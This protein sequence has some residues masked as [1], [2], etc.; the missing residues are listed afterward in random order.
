MNHGSVLTLDA[1]DKLERLRTGEFIFPRDL[2]VS[3]KSR[4]GDD[5]W[6][7]VD[8]AKPRL[9]SISDA[10][11]RIDW[12]EYAQ[13]LS[14]TYEIIEDV[15]RMSLIYT[16]YP[17]LLGNGSAS[18]HPKT[19]VDRTKGV[20]R[21]V[22]FVRD[23]RQARMRIQT[24]A[25]LS[26]DDI[27]VGLGDWQGHRKV[28]EAGLRLIGNPVV[29]VNLA[30]GAPTWTSSDLRGLTTRRE[31][32][33]GTLTL[34][35]GLFRL[36]SDAGCKIT[37]EFLHAMGMEIRDV[38]CRNAV[39]GS[40]LR[41]MPRFPEMFSS[42]VARRRLVDKKGAGYASNHTNLFKREFG[43]LPR[44][45]SDKLRSAQEGAQVL[46]ALYTGMRFSELASLRTD[47]L[48]ERD[49]VPVIRSTLVKHVPTNL[50]TGRDEWVA[51]DI[52]VDAVTALEVLSK[53]VGSD[54]LFCSFERRTSDRTDRPL[55]SSGLA[56][57]WSNFLRT[58]DTDQQWADWKMST[59]QFRNALVLQLARAEVG[60]PY[61]TMHLKH[62]HQCLS[63]VPNQTTIEYGNLKPYLLSQA[64]GIQTAR[65]EMLETI[66]GRNAVVAGGGA[67]KHIERTEDF[68]RGMG[69][70]SD[71]DRDEYVQRLAAS[72]VPLVPTGFGLCGCTSASSVEDAADPPPCFGDYNCRPDIC[73]HSV[74]PKEMKNSLL[75]RLEHAESQLDRPDQAY[76]RRHWTE[77]RRILTSL[78]SSL[79]RTDATPY[80]N[81]D[82]TSIRRP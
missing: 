66:Y 38:H 79:E 20:L 78:I 21:F 29:Q 24:L 62:V 45:L 74:V 31:E 47:C 44:L 27:S 25:D 15:K 32:G 68:F 43:V 72:G 58:H 49:G 3:G 14:L 76:A 2:P 34:P 59:H 23:T 56:S 9:N 50:P 51:A 13:R 55:T 57:R 65:V 82:D 75:A 18:V 1:I 6:T 80:A 28:V 46:I 77:M 42:Y 48:I 5:V 19:V 41:E 53:M 30:Y 61:L 11:L 81:A 70:S 69:L 63:H 54:Y 71:H 39:E 40:W 73:R 22:S 36:L 64:V 16:M 35:D 8:D 26:L 10:H 60:L 33:E 37:G 12:R 17:S 67:A 52:V 7:W 4:F